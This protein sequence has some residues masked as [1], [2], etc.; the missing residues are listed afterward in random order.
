MVETN[1][2]CTAEAM[3]ITRRIVRCCL[4][5][6]HLADP[7]RQTDLHRSS[8][9]FTWPDGWSLTITAKTPSSLILPRG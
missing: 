7:K 3:S 5:I 4:P 8:G 1:Q 2:R 6:D 9:G